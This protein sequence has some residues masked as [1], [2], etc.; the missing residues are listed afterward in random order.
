MTS[1]TEPYAFVRSLL[2]NTIKSVWS[3]LHVWYSVRV[4]PHANPQHIK[5]LNTLWIHVI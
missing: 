5:V 1:S 4:H 2:L 3:L